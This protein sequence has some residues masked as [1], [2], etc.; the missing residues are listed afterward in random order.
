MKLKAFVL[1][2]LVAA[3]FGAGCATSVRVPDPPS[4]VIATAAGGAPGYQHGADRSH[5]SVGA[6]GHRLVEHG[7][8]KHVGDEGTLAIDQINGSAYGVPNANA[9][10]QSLAPFGKSAADHDAFVRDYFTKNGIPADQIGGVKGRTLLEATGRSDEKERPIPKVT[11]YYTVLERAVDGIP[12]VDSFAW[13]RVNVEGQIVEEAVYWPAISVEVMSKVKQLLDVRSDVKRRHE[14][15]A[16]ISA[17]ASNARLVIRHSAASSHDPFEAFACVDVMV[18]AMP[19]E[20]QAVTSYS[21]ATPL[22]ETSYVRHFDIEGKEV[23]L[24]QER[25]RLAHEYP[26]RKVP[27]VQSEK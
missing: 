5:F 23:F 3:V 8:L 24:P 14:L 16:R 1:G 4:G 9:R 21:T 12:V 10:P 18:K 7:Y 22:S 2:T 11:G 20:A 19:A 13:A 27:A 17:D 15:G 6:R 25:F 26:A